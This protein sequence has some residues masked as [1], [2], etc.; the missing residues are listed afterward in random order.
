VSWTLT[1]TGGVDAVASKGTVNLWVKLTDANTGNT[2][3]AKQ[4]L[5]L[6]VALTKPTLSFSA[7]SPYLPVKQGSSV[8]DKFTFTGGG[9][10]HGSLSLSVSGLPSGVTA[11]W[12]ANPVSLN[13]DT[14]SSILTLKASTSTAVN[15]FSFQVTAQGDGLTVTNTATIQVGPAT[16]VE[17]E[18]SKSVLPIKTNGTASL[19]VTANPM[20]SIAVPSNASGS[21]AMITSDLP[22]GIT[23]SW[24]KPSVDSSGNV[25]WTLTLTASSSAEAGSSPVDVWVQITDASRGLVYSTSQRFSVLISLL[26]DV[27]VGSTP[28][29]TI[30]ATFMGLSHEWDA[31]YMIDKFGTGVNPIYRQLLTNLSSY[32]SGPLNVRIGGVS[33]DS[34]GQPTSTTARAFAEVAKSMG[35]KF[36]LGVNLGSDNVQLAVDQAKAFAGQ[37]PSGSLAA[38]EIGNEPDFYDTNGDRSSSYTL[39][40]YFDDFATW[41]ENIMPVLPD[42]VKLMGP[43]WGEPILLANNIQSFLSE[44]STDM[45][46]IS[47]HYYAAEAKNNPA[48]NFLLTPAA[49]T[50]VPSEITTAVAAAHAAG[51][52][53]RMG[54][55]GPA[56]DGGIAGVSDTFSSALWAVDIMYQ[57]ASEGVD[58]MNWETSD[59]NL[60]A[61]F[62][63]AISGTASK[64]TYSLT[65]VH[66]LYYGLL[67]F[68]AATGKGAR[69]LP[70]DLVTSSNLTAWATA[71]SSGTPS[72]VIINKDQAAT[73][74]VEVTEPGYSKASIFR[75]SAPSY[76]STSGV[77]F[78]GQ[79]FDGSK[80]GTIQGSAAIETVTGSNGVFQLQMPV[81]SAALVVFSN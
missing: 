15:W 6:T 78:A 42:G 50:L 81:T 33:T 3:T 69:L 61:P 10:Y 73:G 20:N 62:Y 17:L 45:A 2:Y 70:V 9:S 38:I 54:E 30:P 79:T 51:I 65:F 76:K 39:Q 14:G 8:S 59:A 28:G 60:S 63:A 64:P 68:Q 26:A 74:T 67:F 1:L 35:V 21:S 56:D 72:V 24:G 75:L 32:G 12:S 31:F 4:G 58:G 53:F 22:S 25:N 18:L 55:I 34:S 44:N 37:M 80:D 5:T 77:T 57:F 7:A 29:I 41:K 13:S 71:D 66:P 27:S 48:A 43:S 46:M 36:E 40:D 19:T 11:S 47:Q 16:G 49:A 52:P 23:A